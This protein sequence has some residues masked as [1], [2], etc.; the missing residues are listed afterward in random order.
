MRLFST[1]TALFSTK[2]G[3]R[4]GR[5]CLIVEEYLQLQQKFKRFNDAVWGSLAF[6]ILGLTIFGFQEAMQIPVC[7]FGLG[8]TFLMHQWC[9]YIIGVIKQTCLKFTYNPNYEDFH[10]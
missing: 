4:T 2:I 8:F 6:V 5:L 3:N 7:V 1:Q 9:A 10:W